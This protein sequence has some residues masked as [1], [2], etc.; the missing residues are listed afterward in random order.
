MEAAAAPQAPP[1]EASGDG[2]WSVRE[3]VPEAVTAGAEA[4]S[5]PVQQIAE[6][7]AEE[8][9]LLK[10]FFKDLGAAEREGEVLRILTSFK[11]NP[12]E[13]LNLPL[14]AQPEDVR[15]QYRKISLMVH[16]DKCSHPR[17]RE[18]FEVLG[19]A[20]KM[21][22]N[23]DTWADLTVTFKRAK[24]AVK[25]DYLKEVKGDVA[26]RVRFGGD[27]ELMWEEFVGSNRFLGMWKQK[28]RELLTELEWRRRK[29]NKRIKEEEL[30]AKEEMK[31]QR[32][33]YREEKE[34]EKNWEEKREERVTG[35]RAFTQSQKK[36]KKKT[37]MMGEFR[38]VPIKLP[39]DSNKPKFGIDKVARV[40]RPD[41]VSKAW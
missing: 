24:E 33:R 40:E 29:M 12:F 23:E 37:K 35:W 11:L 20:Q 34:E 19:V 18:A 22:A 27:K 16:P 41:E 14:D 28:A 36:K 17:S 3:F 9:A 2:G 38:P 5:A 21:L 32:K 8:E 15:R 26:M 6:A 25:L 1:A 39:E 10:S 13:H 31:E 7:T 30:K 4:L